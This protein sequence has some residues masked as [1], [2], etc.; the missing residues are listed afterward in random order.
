VL[1]FSG[2]IENAAALN[3]FVRRDIPSHATVFQFKSSL[4]AVLVRDQT[5]FGP[6]SGMEPDVLQKQLHQGQ[7]PHE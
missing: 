6:R 5:M 4:Q 7:D 3:I 2:R 1:Q